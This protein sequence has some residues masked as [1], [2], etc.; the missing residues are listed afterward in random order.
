MWTVALSQSTYSPSIQI[1]LVASIGICIDLLRARLEGHRD[2][3]L[4]PD[5]PRRVSPS[6]GEN[7]YDGLLQRGGGLALAEV[8]E[9]EGGRQHRGDGVRPPAAGDVG[10]GAVDRL[11]Q[12]G[13]SAAIDRGAN[14]RP[15]LATARRGRGL[16][17]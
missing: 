15:C 1:F 13:A 6:A 3:D 8:V 17:L 16:A 11:E 5:L 14:A 9:H 12:R 4:F 2:G 10:G 7:R